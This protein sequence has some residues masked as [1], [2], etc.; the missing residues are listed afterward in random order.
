MTPE[1]EA[2]RARDRFAILS[3]L[4]AGGVVLMAIGLW[5]WLGGSLGGRYGF[6][7]IL[8]VVGVVGAFVVPALVARRWRTPR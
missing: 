8:F 3:G 7:T 5:M 1:E 4:R 2:S 6:G